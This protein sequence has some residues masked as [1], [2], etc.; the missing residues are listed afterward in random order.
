[1]SGKSY[2]PYK[3]KVSSE[4]KKRIDC[5][6]RNLVKHGRAISA[7]D[8]SRFLSRRFRNWTAENKIVFANSKR[9]RKSVIIVRPEYKMKKHK[10]GRVSIFFENY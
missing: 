5:I 10:N 8:D 9:I 1:M 7:G 2:L 6:I 3:M 4:T